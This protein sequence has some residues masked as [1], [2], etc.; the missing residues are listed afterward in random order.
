M[1]IHLIAVGGSV[2]HNFALALHEQGFTITGS[3]DQIYDP[4][5]LRLSEAGL[6]P[7]TE[8]WNE[9]SITPDLDAVII[10]MHA[11]KDN[12]ELLK[13]QTLGLPIYS[14]PEFF[15][16]HTKDKTRVVIAGSHGKTTTTGMILHVLAFLGKETDYLVGAQLPGFTT[17]VK[18]SDAPLAVMEGDEYLSS[19]I[20]D[21]PK[22]MHYHPHI[23]VLT[24]IAW[25][26][27]NVFPTEASYISAFREYL[28]SLPPDATAI[29]DESDELLGS[30]VW[31][32]P[33]IRAVPYSAFP[34]QINDG[35]LF[36]T[37]DDGNLVPCQ[38]IGDHNMRNLMAAW[39]VC[40]QL[41]ISQ[42]QFLSAI[43]TFTGAS[44][45]LELLG[46]DSRGNRVYHDF[47][48]APSK[49]RATVNALKK[50]FS[51]SPL[52]ACL[53]LHTF[54]SLNRDFLHQYSGALNLADSACVF[55][56]PETIAQKRMNALDPDMLRTAF[57]RQNLE[58]LMTTVELAQ[59]MDR[60]AEQRG[61]LLVMSS[62]RLGGFDLHT[63]AREASTR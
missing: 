10:G 26:H 17:M 3:D 12:P 21:R 11:R 29:Y 9:E 53:E 54:S 24:G 22:F 25:D 7:R 31:Q 61:H 56:S 52:S 32:T 28:Q 33:V 62:G 46:E 27:I 15:A 1:K 58:V 23:T 5:R 50:Q 19:P 45:R 42:A 37:P 60:Q 44:R 47:A 2:M 57:S 51:G 35:L 40:E 49:V 16:R 20:D 43:S 63:F 8:G 6:L 59:W 4:A 18:I 13:A 48:H 55:I 34:H 30:L 36:L 38:V 14:F 39:L 41:G